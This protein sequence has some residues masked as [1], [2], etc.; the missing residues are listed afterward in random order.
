[1]RKLPKFGGKEA[2]PAA[3]MSVGVEL[4]VACL[5][6]LCVVIAG[7]AI[8]H[9]ESKNKI[10]DQKV[11]LLT[12]GA[13]LRAGIIGELNRS[14][15]LTSGLRNY[16]AVRHTTLDDREIRN[17]LAAMHEESRHV[18]NFTVAIG[19]RITHIHPLAGNEKA[20]GVEYSDIPAQWP[21]I[22]QA[23]DSGQPALIGPNE[24]LQGGK[25]LIYRVP[26]Y[27]DGRY[28]G[29]V[30]SVINFDTL[31]A[32]V[33]SDKQTADL[34]VALRGKDGTGISGEVFWGDPV[35][36][37]DKN[38]QLL[39]IDI[40]GG[41]WVMGLQFKAPDDDHYLIWL[42]YGLVWLLALAMGWITLIV[43]SQRTKLEHMA[44]FDALTGLPNR[45]LIDDRINRALSGLRRGTTKT[46]LMLFVDL[47][48]FKEINDHFGHHAGDVTLQLTGQRIAG[49][50]RE[51]DTVG[52]WGGD[53]FAV[54]MENVDR[55]SIG[56]I[57]RK[58]RQS[59]EHAM[60][61]GNSAVDIGVSIGYA[62]APDDGRTLDELLRVADERMYAD[63]TA[64]NAS[65]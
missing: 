28:W 50:I 65:R 45:M 33:L 43:L 39:D 6:F 8:V 30:S 51:I 37:G 23:I 13:A 16:L 26:I 5:V 9:L 11:G 1:M 27:F 36:F 7:S 34:R 4:A 12:R 21:A 59:V 41:R 17:I 61:Y 54:C 48:R 64:R 38:T 47:D 25:G 63:K 2:G 40:P 57:S 53:E 3:P 10:A 60:S 52:R 55:T 62:I 56:D 14:L 44:L 29:L 22:K 58:I 35:L 19:L 20:M 31:F 24:L 18:R 32:S 15:Y 49:A 46:C 42:L